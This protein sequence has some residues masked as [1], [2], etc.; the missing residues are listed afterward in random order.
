MTTQDTAEP[1]TPR[2]RAVFSNEDF[3]L[4]KRAVAAFIAAQPDDPDVTKLGHLFHR[5]GRLG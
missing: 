5:L 1:M 3:R 2:P 4:M